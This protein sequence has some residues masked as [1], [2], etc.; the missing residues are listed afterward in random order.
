MPIQN[1]ANVKGGARTWLEEGQRLYVL[2]KWTS[3]E[4]GCESI[5]MKMTIWNDADAD[6]N[7]DGE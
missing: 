7:D 2:R 5:R 6:D 1:D 3:K 4:V